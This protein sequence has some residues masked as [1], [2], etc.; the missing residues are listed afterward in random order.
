MSL[1]IDTLKNLGVM[2][3]VLPFYGAIDEW[4]TLYRSLCWTTYKYWMVKFKAFKRIMQ[5]DKSLCL[6]L[7]NKR[8][9]Y[10]YATIKKNL[11]FLKF[12]CV[13]ITDLWLTDGTK[14]LNYVDWIQFDL[15]ENEYY[16]HE[17]YKTD[18]P[19]IY[20]S[21]VKH[22][23]VNFINSE[24]QK[25]YYNIK[26]GRKYLL[27]PYFDMCKFVKGHLKL[28]FWYEDPK[29]TDIRNYDISRSCMKSLQRVFS[30]LK[31]AQ[32]LTIKNLWVFPTDNPNYYKIKNVNKNKPKIRHII[33]NFDL[34]DI[35]VDN[36]HQDNLFEIYQSSMKTLTECLF[37]YGVLDGLEQLSIND[38]EML[39]WTNEFFED[40]KINHIS[41]NQI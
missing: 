34:P 29:Y 38:E 37:E 1:S 3:N 28:N 9:L 27:I 22:L 30:N 18:C 32:K 7:M 33:L 25:L 21:I 6:E 19:Q 5:K 24:L 13:A 39:N 10:K 35:V 15:D 40:L 4:S 23:V 11:V 8:M 41:I 17:C 16:T 2:L 12:Q 14:N 20:D 31:S 36:H 26:L